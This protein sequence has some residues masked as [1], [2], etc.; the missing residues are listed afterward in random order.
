MRLSC[1]YLDGIY[2]LDSVSLFLGRYG[3]QQEA[4]VGVRFSGAE[5]V[6]TPLNPRPLGEGWGNQQGG[7]AGAA[8]SGANL[9][10]RTLEPG[11]LRGGLG[12]RTGG[13]GGRAAERRRAGQ[14][15]GAGR[16]RPRRQGQRQCGG[17]RRRLPA[18][19]RRRP[20]RRA[21]PGGPTLFRI[22]PFAEQC[23]WSRQSTRQ[24]KRT[25]D[26]LLK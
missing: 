7:Q 25:P 16:E 24:T 4:E 15:R 1:A 14:A 10:R 5:W 2:Y 19:L 6:K 21:R 12:E 26:F 20:A 22:H 17:R 13:P 23:F 18:H 8:L 3:G 11:R 9:L